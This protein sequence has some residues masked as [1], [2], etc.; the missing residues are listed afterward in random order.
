MVTNTGKG[1]Y[2]AKR[3]LRTDSQGCL[4]LKEWSEEDTEKDLRM[5]CL[6]IENLASTEVLYFVVPIVTPPWEA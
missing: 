2:G 3:E 5:A 1:Q 4:T 6:V